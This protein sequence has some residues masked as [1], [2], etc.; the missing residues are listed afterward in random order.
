[1]KQWLAKW[2]PWVM[3]LSSVKILHQNIRQ[4][5]KG[6]VW[7]NPWLPYHLHW[8]PH[9]TLRTKEA[10]ARF[11]VCWDSGFL[12]FFHLITISL[13]VPSLH[14]YLFLSI[15]C[16][17]NRDSQIHPLHN[18]PT[19]NFHFIQPVLIFCTPSAS[20]SPSLCLTKPICQKITILRYLLAVNPNYLPIS[21]PVFTKFAHICSV[22]V[23]FILKPFDS[24]VP[25][26]ISGFVFSTPL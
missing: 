3:R 8:D 24:K 1:M 12:P 14:F 25:S 21:T 11:W 13:L 9:W 5:K 22:V 18:I 26:T 15:N 2:K 7:R 17:L 20:I 6:G 4:S 10:K 16:P 19:P 23:Q